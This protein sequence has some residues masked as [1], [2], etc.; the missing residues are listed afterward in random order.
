MP[1]RVVAQLR[2]SYG[3]CSIIICISMGSCSMAREV[4][5][6]RTVLHHYCSTKIRFE[7]PTQ[8]VTYIYVYIY[9]I[10]TCCSRMS[11]ALHRE[12]LKAAEANC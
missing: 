11:S 2:H 6:R 5:T 1:L 7:P 10:Y 12:I 3:S 9:I 8:R 4:V